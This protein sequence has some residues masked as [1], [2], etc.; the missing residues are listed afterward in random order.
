MD[1]AEMRGRVRADLRDPSAERWDDETLDR[2]IGRAVAELSLA[3]PREATAELMT[4]SGSRDLPLAGLGDRVSIEAVE[5]PAGRYPPVFAPFSAWGDTMSLLVD[6]APAAGEAVLVRYSAMHR[7][8]EEDTSLPEALHD[9]VATG[10]AAYAAIE[11]AAYATNRINT[12]GDDVW[13]RYLSWGQDRL[14]SFSRALAKHGRE[15]RLK[16]RRLYVAAAASLGAR[17]VEG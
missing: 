13:R 1:L 9:L 14:A 15:R 6:G 16:S 3:A 5:Y 4:T 12:G 2:H 8:D 7:L 10:A 11:W 17:P